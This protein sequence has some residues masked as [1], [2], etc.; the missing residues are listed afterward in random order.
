MPNER[1]EED[2][3]CENKYI[4]TVIFEGK[5]SRHPPRRR[6]PK[7]REL[8]HI[9]RQGYTLRTAMAQ[10]IN[11]LRDFEDDSADNNHVR[12]D[13]GYAESD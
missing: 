13:D 5:F 1:H 4:F 12:K 3:L 2:K 9:G 7:A 10:D 11:Y 8:E 6:Y